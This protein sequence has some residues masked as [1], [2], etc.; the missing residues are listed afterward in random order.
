MYKYR[1][2]IKADCLDI[3]KL[4]QISSDGVADYIWHKLAK[5]GENPLMVGR[6]R[7]ERE[8]TDF[9]FEN[10]TLVEK[11]S[12]PDEEEVTVAMMVAF[13]MLV[14]PESIEEDSVLI[15]FSVLEEDNSYYVCGVAVYE[16]HRG[17]GIGNELMAIAEAD[18]VEN[19]MN[20]LSLL[21]FDQNEGAKALYLRLGY[22]IKARH[23]VV[24]HELFH[25]SGDVLLMV[26]D[27]DL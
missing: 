23:K 1:P 8:G 6:R 3:A 24:P 22:V 15:P 21:V 5:D 2:A 25:Y 19:G 13:P 4:Y 11:V 10:C 9:S 26:K 16:Q 17:K 20:K 12:E 18:C 7:Y 14:D 27:L